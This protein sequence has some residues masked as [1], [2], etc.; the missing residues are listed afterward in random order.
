MRPATGTHNLRRLREF[1][2]KQQDEFS[3]IIHVSKSMLQK[4][5]NE[6]KP[7]RLRMAQDIS[8]CTGISAE[9]LKQNDS[10]AAL[11]DTRG[12]PYTL[13]RFELAQLRRLD[14]DPT[15]KPPVMVRTLL[16]QNYAKARD[17]FLRPEMYPHF[18]NYVT[19]LEVLRGRFDLLADY[20]EDWNSA[21][22]ID[23]E[24]GRLHPN[25]LYSGIIRDVEQCQKA[26]QLKAKRIEA[27]REPFLKPS[28]QDR[29]L[30]T[31]KK[32]IRRNTRASCLAWIRTMTK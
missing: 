20:P 14:L 13:E 12:R 21:K 17:L 24:L 23:E 18:V 25:H 11:V 8:A 6:K 4:L 5:E 3:V 2:Q 28:R 9:W 15:I 27:A 29:G 16:L 19:Q 7:L 32:R 30:E 31:I 26:A 1:L 10:R 22:F